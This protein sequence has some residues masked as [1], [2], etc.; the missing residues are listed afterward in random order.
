M[1]PE[2]LSAL[3]TTPA[4]PAEVTKITS[5]ELLALVERTQSMLR[6]KGFEVGMPAFS[7]PTLLSAPVRV[8][9]SPESAARFAFHF[10]SKE[11]PNR[12]YGVYPSFESEARG[13][14]QRPL[15]PGLWANEIETL[16]PALERLMADEGIHPLDS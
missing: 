8:Q 10:S 13:K 2:H 9:R 3:E 12:P 6:D 1:T 7:T 14:T 11:N 16:L 4:P 15:L 5:P